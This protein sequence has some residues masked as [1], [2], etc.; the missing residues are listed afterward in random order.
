MAFESNLWFTSNWVLLQFEK[1]VVLDL[2]CDLWG[3]AY[4]LYLH[5]VV[6]PRDLN[7]DKIAMWFSYDF[8]SGSCFTLRNPLGWTWVVTCEVQH[9]SC[10]HMVWIMIK[11]RCDF[12]MIYQY[13]C[14]ASVWETHRGGIELW[15]AVAYELFPWVSAPMFKVSFLFSSCYMFTHSTL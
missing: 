9:M 14:L 11:Q 10:M 2:S 8:I 7:Y 4:E 1:P 3:A 6:Y 13:L 5:T 15:G 12:H